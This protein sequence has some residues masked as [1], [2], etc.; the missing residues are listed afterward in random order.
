MEHHSARR[1]S[2]PGHTRGRWT[3][4]EARRDVELLAWIDRFRFVTVALAAARFGV[5]ARQMRARLSRLRDEGFVGITSTEGGQERL[6]FVTSRGARALGRRWSGLPRVGRRRAHELALAEFVVWAELLQRAPGVLTERECRRRE[7][8][9]HDTFSI[10]VSG[11]QSQRHWPDVVLVS[12]RGRL[13]I[14]VELTTKGADRLMRIL[15]AYVVSDYAQVVYLSPVPAV[16]RRVEALKSRAVLE[17]PSVAR[18]STTQIDVRAWI[19][20]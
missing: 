15:H 12:K 2:V 1:A 8:H 18:T 17:L 6:V 10:P 19:P 13:A 14:E 7:A 9:K 5:S 16:R 3:R 20:T 11:G 4:V